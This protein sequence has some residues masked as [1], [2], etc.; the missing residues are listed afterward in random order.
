MAVVVQVA[1]LREV[2]ACQYQQFR[3][4]LCEGDG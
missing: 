1:V 3:R 2:R 4:R